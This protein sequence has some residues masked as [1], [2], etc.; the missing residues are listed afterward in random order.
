MTNRKGGKRNKAGE[1]ALD[2][3][4][5]QYPSFPYNRNAPSSQEFYRMCDFFTWDRDDPE[6]EAA[7]EC[8]K[9]ALVQQ[10][11]SVYGTDVNDVESWHKLCLALNLEP[12]PE[13]LSAMRKVG[14]I[15]SLFPSRHVR[16]SN[17]SLP[18]VT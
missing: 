15:L 16:T 17:G 5:E 1:D 12:L 18:N 4:F 7:H 10:F 13:G 9:T 6:R 14:V 8:F 11:N 3:F 2:A